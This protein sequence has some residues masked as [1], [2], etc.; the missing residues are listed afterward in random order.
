MKIGILIDRLNIG[1]VEK[2]AI[3]QVQALR[4]IG[5]DAT[6]VVLRRKAVVPGAFN[7]LIKAIPVEYLDDALPRFCRFSFKFP[8][9]HFF[10]S[11]H[12]TYPFL[13][14]F[15]FPKRKYDVLIAHGTHT[16]LSAIAIKKVKKI[17]FYAYI[18]DPV[19]Y[20]ITRVYKP[21]INKLF[22]KIL[23]TPAVILDKFILSE[24]EAIMVGGS[25][26]N[27][28]L[29]SLKPDVKIIN[30]PPS[31][32]ITSTPTPHKDNY[33]LLVTAWKRG[34]SPEFIFE[35]IKR[36]PKAHFI[37]AGGWIDKKYKE[38]FQ[39]K[40]KTLGLNNRIQIIGRVSEEKLSNLYKRAL[41]FLQ[42]NDDRG[43]GMPAL[44]A[45]AHGT[46]FIIPKGQGVCELFENYKDGF[47]VREKDIE[48]ISSLL[49][50]LLA[51]KNLA[52]E[53]GKNAYNKFISSYT[54]D[55]YAYKLINVISKNV[56]PSIV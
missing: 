9:F 3:Q 26:H 4:N 51:N 11:F 2:I 7:E 20:I 37:L 54:W 48:T 55:H 8:L 12:L 42:I 43:F 22:Y 14:P 47:F 32:Y 6:L 27:N 33:I 35:L 40:V 41:V 15:V 18:W 5:V 10:S 19:S 17:P 21:H 31:T 49:K 34:K 23:Y 25:A 24:A 36:L 30:L 39:K 13:I 45:A 29:Y 46:T 53:M 28:I 44:E 50:K 56:R 16:S 38:E 1:G 52:I